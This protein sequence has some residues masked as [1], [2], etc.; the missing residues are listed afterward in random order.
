MNIDRA[1]EF[2]NGYLHSLRRLSGN[3][4]DFWVENFDINET[5]ENDLKEHLSERNVKL[6]DYSKIGYSQIRSIINETI[7][8]N[9]IISDDD[10]LKLLEW[11]IIENMEM[12]YRMIEPETNPLSDGQ[13]MLFNANSDFHGE[14]IFGYP[15]SQKS[16]QYRGSK[17]CL[18]R[19]SNGLPNP[20][21]FVLSN[22]NRQFCQ[23]L[24]AAL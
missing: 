12:T 4:C 23:P 16:G 20:S 9:L 10:T 8:K 3:R 17:P 15:H 21:L 5:I 18:T 22:K 11:D 6:G 1:T 13:V 14:Y 7:L 24:C 2:L 19:R